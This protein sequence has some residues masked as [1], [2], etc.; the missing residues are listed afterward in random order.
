[1]TSALYSCSLALGVRAEAFQMRAVMMLNRVVEQGGC[2]LN[3]AVDLQVH[4]VG[5]VAMGWEEGSGWTEVVIR[6][7]DG[8]DGKGCRGG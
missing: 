2:C 3:A 8:D 1:M 4:L 6:G 5:W 7:I